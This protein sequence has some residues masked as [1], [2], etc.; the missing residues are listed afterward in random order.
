MATALVVILVA[1]SI[2][3]IA[4]FTTSIYLHRGLTHGSLKVGRFMSAVFRVIL[5]VTTGQDR[6]EWVAVHRKHHAFTDVPGDPH[7][8]LLLGFW[9]VQLWNVYYYIRE[10]RNHETIA[11]YT[12]GMRV[13]W[14]DR[15]LAKPIVGSL[16]DL[17]GPVLGTLGLCWIF[18]LWPAISIAF[19]HGVLYVFVV[20]PLINAV[21]HRRNG[22]R[23]YLDQ[24]A[25]NSKLLAW[26]T[27]GESLHNNHH[28]HQRSPRFA[29]RR[30]EVDPSWPVIKVL[31]SLRLLR[32]TARL[33]VW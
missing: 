30:G 20:A 2:T 24:T 13:D 18:G 4:T 16:F 25:T 31:A 5:W 12:K 7:S 8:P 10:A 19:L 23:N 9:R 3:T 33:A 6:R 17:A 29:V 21:G 26:F 22:A 11:K 32:I 28:A 27:A 1:L 14:W 15:L